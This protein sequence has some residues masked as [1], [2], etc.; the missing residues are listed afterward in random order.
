MHIERQILGFGDVA[1]IAIDIIAQSREG[2]FFDLDRDGA[3][4]DLRKIENVVDEVEQIGAGG[5]DVAGEFDL[6]L[7]KVAGGFSA[8]C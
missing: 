4:F 3:G 6:L 1:E 5:I 8:S 2:D 7:G